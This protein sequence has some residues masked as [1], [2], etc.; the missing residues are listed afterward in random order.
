MSGHVPACFVDGTRV[1]GFDEHPESVLSVPDSLDA[2]WAEAEAALG[3]IE[4]EA[5]ACRAAWAANPA[6]WGWHIHHD[7]LC[8]ERAYPIEDRIAYILTQKPKAERALRLRLMRP[9]PAMAPIWKTYDDALAPIEKTY[10]DA[11][12][13]IWKTYD[14]ALAPIEK[15]YGDARAPIEKTYG[16]AMAAIEKTCADARAPIEK[17]YGDARAPIWKTYDDALAP[18]WKTYADA[19]AP[20]EKTYGDAMAPIQKTY[21]DAWAPIWKTYD[22]A[23]AAAHAE[24]CPG[25]P[26]DGETIFGGAK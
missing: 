20:I 23:R 26:W 10:G 22:D 2:A 4:E 17:T 3:T 15:T 16:D 8:E 7:T 19:R 24:Q 9:A 11:M 1:C 25:C 12:A 6:K 13:P 5:A 18:I 21:D 14:D